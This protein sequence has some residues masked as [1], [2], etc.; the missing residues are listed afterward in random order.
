MTEADKPRPR[1]AN[2][3]GGRQ[4][5]PEAG[6]SCQ[7]QINHARGGQFET[8]FNLNSASGQIQKISQNNTDIE[9]L[10]LEP[11]EHSIAHIET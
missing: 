7:R 10:K 1:R 3:A 5:M 8:Y 6:K 9:S 2:H 4:A 11:F